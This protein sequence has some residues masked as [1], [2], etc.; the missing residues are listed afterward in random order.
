MKE[1]T[2]WIIQTK[3]GKKDGPF[4]TQEV[5]QKIRS[6]I[7]LGEESVS[8]YPTG[9][10]CLLSHEEQFFDVIIKV[11]EED[12]LDSSPLKE[13][14]KEELTKRISLIKEEKSRKNYQKDFVYHK[15]E[16]GQA[17]SEDLDAKTPVVLEVRN[18]EGKELKKKGNKKTK[19]PIRKKIEKPGFLKKKQNLFSSIFDFFS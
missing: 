16:K 9:Q 18:K 6:G 17:V 10:W 7:Y 12:L 2:Q 19:K 11:L 15:R 1:I 8:R 13:E 4:S 3:E 14:E 5:I